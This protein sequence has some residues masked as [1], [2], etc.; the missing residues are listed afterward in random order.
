MLIFS[1]QSIK[2]HNVD[3]PLLSLEKLFLVLFSI[4]WQAGSFPSFPVLPISIED[5]SGNEK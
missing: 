1:V 5:V 4:V 3:S 2:D